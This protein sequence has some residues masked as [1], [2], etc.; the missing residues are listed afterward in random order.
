[1]SANFKEKK[2]TSRSTK[3]KKI[4]NQDMLISPK[5]SVGYTKKALEVELYGL[6]DMDSQ[7]NEDYVKSLYGTISD[8]KILEQQVSDQKLFDKLR[9]GVSFKFLF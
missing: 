4:G 3:D 8:P 1:M 7:F 6:Y 2:P 5:L 9:L